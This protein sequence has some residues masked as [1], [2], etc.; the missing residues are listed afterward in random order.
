MSHELKSNC[1]DEILKYIRDGEPGE[2]GFEFAATV[3]FIKVKLKESDLRPDN[4]EGLLE[5]IKDEIGYYARENEPRLA[6]AV[7]SVLVKHGSIDLDADGKII[8]HEKKLG[9]NR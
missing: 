7:V 8:Y 9:L 2:F 3:D 5:F 4:V 6:P 1:M